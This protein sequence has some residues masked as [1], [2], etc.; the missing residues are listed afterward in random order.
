LQSLVTLSAL[1]MRME[2][3]EERAAAWQLAQKKEQRSLL[4][5][6]IEITSMP[7]AVLENKWK[8]NRSLH[9]AMELFCLSFR[10]AVKYGPS[11][12]PWFRQCWLVLT[13]LLCLAI[14]IIPIK[15][16]D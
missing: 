3:A 8:N 15:Q 1:L 14:S 12:C 2:K 5:H 4:P 11:L 7:G 10:H 9:V 6:G 16:L 13:V